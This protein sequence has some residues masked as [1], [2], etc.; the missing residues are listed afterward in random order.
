M[1]RF[2][3]EKRRE[4]LTGRRFGQVVVV[5]YSR[6][7]KGGDGTARAI[8]MIRCDCGVEEFTQARYLKRGSKT[9]CSQCNYA[10]HAAR[11]RARNANRL[12]ESE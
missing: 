8:W 7:Y 3:G 9:I 1:N 2:K 12:R 5:R 10:N 6:T 4:D 11:M